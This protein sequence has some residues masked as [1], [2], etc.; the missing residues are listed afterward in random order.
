MTRCPAHGNRI[1][2]IPS[3]A[4]NLFGATP[5]PDCRRTYG[6]VLGGEGVDA[7]EGPAVGIEVPEVAV[8]VAEAASYMVPGGGQ[9]HG[10]CP[11]PPEHASSLT[12]LPWRRSPTDSVA[13]RQGGICAERAASHSPSQSP[14]HPGLPGQVGHS[15]IRDLLM[16]SLHSGTSSHLGMARRPCRAPCPMRQDPRLE[17]GEAIINKLE[18]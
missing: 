10:L 4:V 16:R 12:Q 14:S 17:V 2:L 13:V 15:A 6:Y 5:Q 9:G 3:R 18:E 11:V 7:F 8:H 1:Q